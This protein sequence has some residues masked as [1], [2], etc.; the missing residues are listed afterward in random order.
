MSPGANNPRDKALQRLLHENPAPEN[1]A[2]QLDKSFVSNLCTPSI[3]WKW[4]RC[5]IITIVLI[6]L[7]KIN[8]NLL[9][10]SKQQQALLNS[11]LKTK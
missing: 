11:I 2:N 7:F 1:I 10:K 3:S 5:A 4:M 8:K 6:V 9:A